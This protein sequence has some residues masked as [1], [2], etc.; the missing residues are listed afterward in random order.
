MVSYVLIT[1]VPV[2]SIVFLIMI[3][4]IIC[5]SVLER[6][7]EI[8]IPRA[9]GTSK[10]NVSQVLDAET[11]IID[12]CSGLLDVGLTVL[13]NIPI[14]AM[15]HHF[16]DNVDVSAALPVIGGVVL[17]ILSVVLTLIGNLIPSCEVAKQD[18]ATTLRTE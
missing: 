13:L 6:T 1:F 7:K 5:I 8:G 17:V 12:L 14:N 3:G 16:I 18:P 9:M 11:G 4:V 10:H 2:S 15:L